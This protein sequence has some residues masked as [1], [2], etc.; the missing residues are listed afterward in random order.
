[1]KNI[2]E[3][4]SFKELKTNKS[5]IKSMGTLSKDDVDLIS[6]LILGFVE[7]WEINEK[8]F[9]N[10]YYTLDKSDNFFIN[11]SFFIVPFCDRPKPIV[12][13]RTK[14]YKTWVSQRVHFESDLKKLT[15]RIKKFDYNVLT[16]CFGN[17]DHSLRLLYCF[18][19]SH[20]EKKSLEI[21]NKSES[22]SYQE[23]YFDINEDEFLKSCES[24]ESSNIEYIRNKLKNDLSNSL[25]VYFR[26]EQET[27][28]IPR[29]SIDLHDL[30]L[31]GNTNS[32]LRKR[33][34]I[35]LNIFKG[36]DEWY[37]IKEFSNRGIKFYKCDQYDGLIKYIKNHE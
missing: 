33:G 19:I 11:L 25:G 32:V 15:E 30:V 35:A 10:S 9:E 34:N 36:D 14:I 24:L 17:K 3:Y 20:T 37:F 21:L 8:R 29:I 31:S 7:K 26:K 23:F 13:H 12:D 27:F 6:D 16:G 2:I 5:E 1:M 18:S 28:L 4:L 22:N